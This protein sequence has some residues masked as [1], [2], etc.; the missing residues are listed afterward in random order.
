MLKAMDITKKTRV[1]LEAIRFKQFY[2]L[3]IT[4]QVCPE[5][6]TVSVTVDLLFFG[7]EIIVDWDLDEKDEY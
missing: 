3:G 5:Y 7:F 2:N 1:I 6:T 4:V